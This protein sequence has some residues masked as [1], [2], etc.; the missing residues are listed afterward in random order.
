ME[1]NTV[2]IEDIKCTFMQWY[3]Y[4]HHILV[5]ILKKLDY[6]N[7]LAFMTFHYKLSWVLKTE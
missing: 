6:I 2:L 3:N 4:K 1:I 7:I 5:I